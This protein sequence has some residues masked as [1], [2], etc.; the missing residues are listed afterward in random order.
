LR[1]CAYRFAGRG[2]TENNYVPDSEVFVVTERVFV[3]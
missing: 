1:T 3:R 2:K